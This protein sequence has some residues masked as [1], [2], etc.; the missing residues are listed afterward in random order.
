MARPLAVAVERVWP[1]FAGGQ[2]VTEFYGPCLVFSRVPCT[3]REEV[4]RGSRHDPTD[5][6]LCSIDV[7]ERTAG[8]VASQQLVTGSILNRSATK[9]FGLS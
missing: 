4:I 6:L 9:L 3:S 8:N 5:L 2:D 1:G 7:A